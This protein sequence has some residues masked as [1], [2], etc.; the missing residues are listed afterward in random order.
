MRCSVA[1]VALL[2][3]SAAAGARADEQVYVRDVTAAEWAVVEGPPPEVEV[4][5]WAAALL[6]PARAPGP[7]S[8]LVWHAPPLALATTHARIAAL[9]LRVPF[10]VG[11]ELD[12]LRVLTLRVRYHDALVAAINGVEVARRNL[13]GAAHQ[14]ASAQRGHG[15][16][17]EAIYVAV[18]P[19]LIHA[20]ANQLEL[21][22]RPLPAR[23]APTVEL[24]L[25]GG[26]AGRIVRGPIVQR[27]GERSATI[28]F[29][30]DLPVVGT[31]RWG[32]AAHAYDHH[33]SDPAPTLRHELALADLPAG[34]AV[35]YT[36]AAGD[37][38]ESADTVF[39]TTPGR[40]D[41]IR[42]VVYGDVRNGHDVHAE[43]LR[44]VA[45]EAPD[46]IVSTGDMVLRGT[47]EADW[48]RY[49]R[50]S[51][52]LMARVPLYPVMGNHDGGGAEAGL[53][54]FDDI[55]A[56]PERPP[57]CPEGAAWYGFDVGP[58]HVLILDS[59][60]YDDDRQLEWV[61]E[62]LA[63]ARAR[64][65][66]A[67]FAAAHA[68]PYSRGPHGGD[69][70]AASRYAPLLVHAGVTV[71]FSGHD[72][73]YERGQ[74]HGLHYVVS[75][76]GG[77]ELYAPRC[78]VRGRPA[79]KPDGAEAVVSAHHYVVAEVYRDFVRLCAKRPDGTPLEACQRIDL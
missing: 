60:R 62:D 52:E 30:T 34:G 59:N 49:F 22:V 13:D 18:T 37:D 20:G 42:F 19:G 35:H 50:I 46:F 32:S 67:I 39:H 8:D 3:T 14:A 44:S 11:A 29:E 51:G 28:V 48:Q 38:A 31:V 55:F 10:E 41:V 16:E 33:A 45:A 36:I 12:R 74:V 40:D 53:R 23:L 73:L 17:D 26:E 64:G 43:I 70:V 9:H 5:G 58:V 6:A 75:G 61:A 56:L 66:R 21:D 27:L 47:D 25:T 4:G 2:A 77:A 79:C 68:G 54:H 15:T 76:G 7:E 78:G 65:V 24:A 1:C 71:F 63:A 69:P 72:H 57:G